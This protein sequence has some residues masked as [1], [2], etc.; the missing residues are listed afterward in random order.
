ME[1]QPGHYHSPIPSAAEVEAFEREAPRFPG[2]VEGMDLRLDAHLEL[3]DQLAPYDE[4]QPFTDDGN[5][6]TRYRFP[7]DFFPFADAL[8]LYRLVRHPRPR[9]MIEVGSARKLLGW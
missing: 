4:D 5:A 3:L 9:R 1:Y 2:V 8:T 7:N 6:R